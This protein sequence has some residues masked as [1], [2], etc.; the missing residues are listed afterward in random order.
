MIPLLSWLLPVLPSSCPATVDPYPRCPF[1]H[2][3]L[4]KT[5]ISGFGLKN[6]VTFMR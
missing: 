4:I 2:A 5:F 1:C 3:D 6:S